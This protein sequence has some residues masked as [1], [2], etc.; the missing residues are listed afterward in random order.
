MSRI[1][2]FLDTNVLLDV[3]AEDDRPQKAASLAIFHAIRSSR[4]EAVLTTQS[5]IDASYILH[6][7]NKDADYYGR[8]LR[9]YQFIN[10]DY[11]NSFDVRDACLHPTGDFEDDALYARAVD[12]CCDVFVTN[13]RKLR[14]RRSSNEDQILFLSPEEFINKITTHSSVM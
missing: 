8:V 13:D 11:L 10:I 12:T 5:I 1:K 2:V 6:K 4:I 7:Q 3:L 9:M 14:E